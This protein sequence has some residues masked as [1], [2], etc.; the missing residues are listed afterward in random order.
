MQQDKLAILSAVGLVSADAA[1]LPS[2]ALVSSQ[3][4]DLSSG[5][6]LL[7]YK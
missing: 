7:H 3:A 6:R 1:V 2:V 4:K 5:T